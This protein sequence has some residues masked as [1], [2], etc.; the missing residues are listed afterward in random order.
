MTVKKSKVDQ[1]LK[2]IE[3][4]SGEQMGIFLAQ[5]FFASPHANVKNRD[6]FNKESKCLSW[7]QVSNLDFKKTKDDL[8][9]KVLEIIRNQMSE[10]M[11]TSI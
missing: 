9:V 10:E 1:A 5:S 7:D 6:Y 2:L 4:L 8:E 3:F 11:K